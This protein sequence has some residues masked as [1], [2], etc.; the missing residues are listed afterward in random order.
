M[1]AEIVVAGHICLD[2]IPTFGGG[3]QSLADILVP[4][5]LVN[6]GAAVM[7][8][9]G[10]VSNTGLAL[11][12]LGAPTRLMGKVGDDVIGHAIIEIVRGYGPELAKGMLVTKE[13]PSSYTVVIS[14]PGV[15]RIFL[16]CPGANDTF[17]AADVPYDDLRGAKLFHFGYPPLMKR[18]FADGGREL[19]ALLRGVKERGVTTSLDMAKPDPASE[20]GKAPWRDILARA[21]PFVDVFLPSVDEILFMLD[22]KRFDEMGPELQSR[23]DGALLRDLSDQ[24]LAMGVAVVGLKL[25]AEGLYLRTTSDAARLERLEGCGLSDPKAWRNRELL[26]PCF[27]VEVEGTTGSGDCTIA[28][29]L[30]GLSQGQGPEA[31][32]TSA[33]AVGACN[34]EKADATSGIRSWSEVQARIRSGWSRRPMG[35]ALDGWQWEAESAVWRGPSDGR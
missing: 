33:V 28:G 4:G 14:P 13:S 30:A 8:T 15:D 7:A 2:I 18:M 29:F 16:H 22:R 26:A 19:V 10:L 1:N 32:V 12:R 5:K 27:E 35:V 6:V 20:A 31:A 34:V 21:L 11:H 23:L 3:A 25:G 24:L 9:G 17:G